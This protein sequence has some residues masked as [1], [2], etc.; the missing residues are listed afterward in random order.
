MQWDIPVIGIQLDIDGELSDETRINPNRFLDA[1]ARKVPVF[2][3]PPAPETFYWTYSDAV[4]KG[5]SAIISVHIASNLSKTYDAAVEAAKRIPIPVHVID[6][7]TAGSQ[8]GLA[9]LAAARVAQAGGGA[10]RVLTTLNKRLA[11]SKELFYVDTLEF[12]R[13][14]GRIGRA[15]AFLGST[16]HIKPILTVRDGVI[17]PI[18]RIRGRAKAVERIKGLAIEHAAG[19]VCDVSVEYVDDSSTANAILKELQSI[20]PPGGDFHLL[21]ASVV[22]AAHVGPG[23]FAIGIAPK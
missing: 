17:E 22:L 16:F 10:Q 21:P 13:R 23:A 12:L 3:A 4:N 7:K 14:G 11:D 8:L 20:L 9:V 5:A 15:A 19:R 1:M 18:E 2:T 6:S